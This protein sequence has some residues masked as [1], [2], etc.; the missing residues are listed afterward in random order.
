MAKPGTDRAA[1][2]LAKTM[3]SASTVT[4]VNVFQRPRMSTPHNLME[5]AHYIEIPRGL[6]IGRG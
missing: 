3:E 2:W 1:D 6:A 5:N 4:V